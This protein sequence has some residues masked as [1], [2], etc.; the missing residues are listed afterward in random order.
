MGG[1]PSLLLPRPASHPLH[2][3]GQSWDLLPTPGVTRADRVDSRNRLPL[4]NTERLSQCTWTCVRTWGIMYTPVHINCAFCQKQKLRGL[5][6][7]LG[8]VAL[9]WCARSFAEN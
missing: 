8:E 1:A 6:S 2:P 7:V 4:R 3:F 9:G 5:F